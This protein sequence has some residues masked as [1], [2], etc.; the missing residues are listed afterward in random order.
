VHI[1]VVRNVDKPSFDQLQYTVNI[2]E[3]IS[4]GDVVFTVTANDK[5][6]VSENYEILKS[7]LCVCQIIIVLILNRIFPIKV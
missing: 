5:D 7:E 2:T 4:V 6:S 3:M 1:K